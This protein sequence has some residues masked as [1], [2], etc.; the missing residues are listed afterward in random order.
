MNSRILERNK[1]FFNY[2]VNKSLFSS[3]GSDKDSL[4]V[5]TKLSE[6]A[7]RNHPGFL[8]SSEIEK[9][10]LNLGAKIEISNIIG[11]DKLIT[12]INE[13]QNCNLAPTVFHI[14][15]ELADYGGHSRIQIQMIRKLPKNFK[16]VL[17]ILNQ[18]RENFPKIILELEGEEVKI[19]SL[20]NQQNDISK[21]LVLRRITKNADYIILNHHPNDIIPLLAY[22]VETTCPVLVHNHAHSWFW[23][24]VGITD[25][26]LSYDSFHMKLNEDKRCCR[27]NYL[28]NATQ[29]DTFAANI[30]ET[31]KINAKRELGLNTDCITLLS[32]GTEEKFIPNKK[33]NFF[34]LIQKILERYCDIEIV[35]IGLN[36]YSKYIP[37]ALLVNDRVRFC[38][39]LNDVSVY[40]KA[41]DIFLES[42]PQ[43][44]FGGTIFSNMEG[45]AC[46]LYKY[47][48]NGIYSS[49]NFIF[50][51]SYF[52][53]LK[54]A[55]NQTEYFDNLHIL[56]SNKSI[57]EEIALDLRNSLI[58]MYNG[59]RFTQSI[60]D[61]FEY[62]RKIKH[63]HTLTNIRVPKPD[64]F[65]QE[66]AEG[67]LFKT[68]S[69]V[70][71]HFKEFLDFNDKL[72][73]VI[74]CLIRRIHMRENLRL[75]YKLL[76]N[77]ILKKSNLLYE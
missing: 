71:K 73:L 54:H 75:L 5:I 53:Y 34:Q 57:R 29:I 64:K 49:E 69:E 45:L 21:A 23:L 46:P 60:I 12:E 59:D 40:Y 66:I 63:C 36:K 76:S 52:K 4:D 41:A 33:Y 22:S 17:V 15:S 7:W 18:N 55:K 1:I 61:L 37:P 31:D 19:I 9:Y 11:F 77:R 47:G 8:F 32:L 65:D 16:Q 2:I 42:M 6:F 28:L 56:I 74:A 67:S 51:E 25:V 30:S 24:G 39:Y 3:G 20:N 58:S 35:I 14:A 62:S 70:F 27:N 38:G 43:P 26:L 13:Y 68:M 10:L 50:S 72:R 44:S 48:K